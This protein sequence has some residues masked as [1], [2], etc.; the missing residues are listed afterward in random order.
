MLDVNVTVMGLLVF[1]LP[2]VAG[3]SLLFWD[4]YKS[5]K[6]KTE[7]TRLKTLC[8]VAKS[9]KRICDIVANC[10]GQLQREVEDLKRNRKE[11]KND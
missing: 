6:S 9:E 1:M 11:N 10:F 5:L 3:A 2:L 7:I 8:E 4:L